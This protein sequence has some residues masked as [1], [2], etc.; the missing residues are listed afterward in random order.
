MTDHTPT[1]WGWHIHDASAA[2][3]EGPKSMEDH[4][5]TVSPCKH[6]QGEEWQWS[7]CTNPSETDAFFIV[8]AVN[9]YDLLAAPLA[10][11]RDARQAIFDSQTS[12]KATAEQFARLGSAEHALMDLARRFGRPGGSLPEETT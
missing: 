8:E 11:W 12:I 9:A 5:L 1:P 3:L 10:E 2:S 7:A 6:C 4:V